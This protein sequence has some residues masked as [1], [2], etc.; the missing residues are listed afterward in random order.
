MKLIYVAG[1]YRATSKAGVTRNINHAKN[2]AKKLWV[3]GWSV[4]CPHMNTAH[5]DGVV[6]E[7]AFLAGDIEI[8]KRCDAIWM[9]LGWDKSLGARVEM[10]LAK[11]IGLEVYYE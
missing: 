9:L 4:I 2:E 3:A 11:Q 7:D 10:E 1:P 6:P 8:L 5:L